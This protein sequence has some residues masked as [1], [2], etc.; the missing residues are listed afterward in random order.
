MS[1]KILSLVS[2]IVSV[3]FAVT[4]YIVVA[5]KSGQIPTGDQAWGILQIAFFIAVVF[6]PVDISMIIQNIR[7]KNETKIP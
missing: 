6:G 7:G 4:A 1:A 2:K 5:V 3:A